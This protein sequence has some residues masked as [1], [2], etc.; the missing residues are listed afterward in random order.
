[1]IMRHLGSQL[2]REESTLF[3]LSA[4]SIVAAGLAYRYFKRL[5]PEFTLSH[6]KTRF[7]S[8]LFASAKLFAL[9]YGG[10]SLLLFLAEKLPDS[11]TPAAIRVAISGDASGGILAA[12]PSA[13]PILSALFL[14][15]AC[16]FAPVGEELLFRRFIY[17]RMRS[18]LSPVPAV[19]FVSI[20]FSALHQESGWIV[21]L[22]SCYITAI[23]E[24]KSDIRL[25]ILLHSLMNI[26]TT[27]KHL[28]S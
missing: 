12:D 5:E 8:A 20:L 10:A 3:Y 18:V 27:I 28:W 16:I 21:F 17:T 9:Y 6:W 25:T 26:S 24:A 1:M 22:F 19:L 11:L 4:Q 7:F 23:Y 13:A 2:S 15:S 14:I